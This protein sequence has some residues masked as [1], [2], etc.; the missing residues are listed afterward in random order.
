MCAETTYISAKTTLTLKLLLRSNHPV[1]NSNNTE[2]RRERCFRPNYIAPAECQGPHYDCDKRKP[3]EH[4]I[5]MHCETTAS[6]GATISF[7]ISGN[8]AIHDASLT[9][10]SAYFVNQE[11]RVPIRVFVE[12][13]ST[14]TLTIVTPALCTKIQE[15]SIGQVRPFGAGVRQH[16][17]KAGSSP[18]IYSTTSW[19][20]RRKRHRVRKV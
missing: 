8:G 20:E 2:G 16:A 7:L 3:K 9:T 6:V 4:N 1:L 17:F 18:R 15:D 19:T 13:G 10:A 12:A 14:L 5:S 11:H